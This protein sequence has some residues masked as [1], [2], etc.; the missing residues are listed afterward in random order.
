M[1]MFKVAIGMTCSCLACYY[2]G[3]INTT[4]VRK[5]V[6]GPAR[7][8]N[9]YQADPVTFFASGKLPR[10]KKREAAQSV[11]SM[12]AELERWGGTCGFQL[13][14]LMKKQHCLE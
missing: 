13:V 6:L 3:V 2:M 9:A 5:V 11:G 7:L 4:Y 12:G 8:L 14:A 1:R 10:D